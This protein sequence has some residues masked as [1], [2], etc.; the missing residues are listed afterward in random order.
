MGI[1]NTGFVTPNLPFHSIP[2]QPKDEKHTKGKN[3]QQF[4]EVFANRTHQG[5]D[6]ITQMDSQGGSFNLVI[7]FGMSNPRLNPPTTFQYFPECMRIETSC[8]IT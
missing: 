3:P 4:A 5:F 2:A 6:P 1:H 8:L 7:I